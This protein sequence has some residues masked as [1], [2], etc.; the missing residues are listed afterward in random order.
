MGSTVLLLHSASSG[1]LPPPPPRALFGRDDLIEKIVDLAENITPVALTGPGGIGKTS[2]ALTVLHHYRIKQRFG[3]NRR[4]IR[5]DRFPASRA[6]FLGQ[7]SRA[8]GAG[9][10]NPRDLTPLRHFLSSRTMILFIDNAESILDSPGTEAEEIYAMVEELS[11]FSNICLCL[12]SRISTIPPDFRSLEIPTLSMDAACRTFY[13]IYDGNEPSNLVNAILEQL[14]FHPLSIM[15]LATAAHQNKWGTERLAREWD[16]QRTGVLHAQPNRSLAA[17][18]ELSLASPT[19]QELGP[20]ARDL[21]GVVAFFPQGVD[22]NNLDWLFPD[23]PNITN[24][25]DKFGVL[26][27]TYRNNGFVTMLAPLRDYLRPKDPMTSPLLCATKDC[28]FRRLSIE[29]YPDKP[30]YKDARWIT[31]EDANIEHL[32]NIFTSINANSNDIWTACCNFM[33]HLHWHKSRPVV[34]GPKIEGLPDDHPLK[35]HCLFHLSWSFVPVGN[36]AE[37]KRLLVYTLKIWRERGNDPQIARTLTFLAEANGL[38]DLHKEGLEQVEEAL[39]I[40][41]RL[42]DA[43][44]QAVSLQFRAFL[45]QRNGQLD[46]AEAAASRAIN[47]LPCKD[48]KFRACRSHRLLGNIYRCNNKTEQATHHLQTALGIASSSE[49]PRE[50]FWNHYYLGQLFSTQGRFDDAQIHIE[51]AKPHVINSPYHMGRA[52]QLQAECW[53]QQRKFE[54]AKSETLRAVEVFEKVGALKNEKDCRGLLENIER[55]MSSLRESDSK[56]QR[57]R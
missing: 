42:N 10:E 3:E 41:E 18:I 2:I 29:V 56:Y 14:D 13:H 44:G 6:H 34:L 33:E 27:L 20:N 37:R 50:Q 39:R 23:V 49:W 7:L 38:L 25:F 43:S 36:H 47:L 35:P 46:A 24:I 21:L 17:T 1:E 48:E 30:G 19:F 31:S 45:L 8:I 40:Y 15:L 26:S 5:C 11:R 4:F 51:R 16:S 55:G 52:M 28:Y 32:L 57:C 54:E 9:V 12:T 53:Y 22:E